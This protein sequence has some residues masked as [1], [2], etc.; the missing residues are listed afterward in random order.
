LARVSH[1]GWV[2]KTKKAR[3]IKD[4]QRIKDC[5][6]G[7]ASEGVMSMKIRKSGTNM[8]PPPTPDAADNTVQEKTQKVSQ[9]SLPPKEAHKF[10]LTQ[11][12]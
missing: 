3:F 5:D 2:W 4:E 11:M 12:F 8:P 6:N 7:T 1:N 10:R 9:A